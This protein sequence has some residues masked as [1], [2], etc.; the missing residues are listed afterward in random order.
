M[1]VMSVVWWCRIRK[2]IVVSLV[3]NGVVLFLFLDDT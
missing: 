2:K 1:H 3:E